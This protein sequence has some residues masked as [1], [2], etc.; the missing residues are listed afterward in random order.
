MGS[1]SK[2]NE[3]PG[4]VGKKDKNYK[5]RLLNMLKKP[6]EC[7]E[8]IINL[9]KCPN[10][11]TKI[12]KSLF[13]FC[14]KKERTAFWIVVA[15]F[16]VA[17]GFILYKDFFAQ[18]IV[19]ISPLLEKLSIEAL[20]KDIVLNTGF[21]ANS[22]AL[23]VD[24]AT[25]PLLLITI[26]FSMHS[27]YGQSLFQNNVIHFNKEVLNELARIVASYNADSGQVVTEP[28]QSDTPNQNN[29]ISPDVQ[30]DEI[31]DD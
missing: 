4:Q 27:N 13:D 24:F 12:S 2:Q 17:F 26:M 15:F 28:F 7:I 1:D 23:F 16:V 25:L 21:F 14:G 9:F 30:N 19:D 10:P 18:T 3:T 11:I 20:E 31:S 8:K 6:F 29:D 22:A 5:Q